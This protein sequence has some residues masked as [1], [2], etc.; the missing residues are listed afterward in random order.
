VKY[1]IAAVAL[2]GIVGIIV[3]TTLQPGVL[4]IVGSAVLGFVVFL[5]ALA[6]FR[7]TEDDR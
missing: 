7:S 3:V 1:R 6:A 5:V 2:A 4:E